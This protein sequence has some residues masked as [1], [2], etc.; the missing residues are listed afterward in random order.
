MTHT[1]RHLLNVPS[2]PCFG[3]LTSFHVLFGRP[4]CKTLHCTGCSSVVRKSSI[5]S[6]TLPL[7]QILSPIGFFWYHSYLQEPSS[8]TDVIS[9]RLLSE[10]ILSPVGFLWD[11]S[12]L[13]E[14]YLVTGLI[15][16][17]LLLVGSSSITDWLLSTTCWL[18]KRCFVCAR[19]T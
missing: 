6:C 18:G 4:L 15:Y 1:L 9:S 16:S 10:R 8:G 17:R 14:A 11:R 19:M 13:Q 2:T 12:Y 3:L 5:I 7:V